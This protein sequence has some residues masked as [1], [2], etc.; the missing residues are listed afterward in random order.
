MVGGEHRVRIDIPGGI[1]FELAEIGKA[2]TS[3]SGGSIDL[4]LDGSYG[5]FNILRH[6]ASGV[7]R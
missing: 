6:S 2:T 7:V 4:D 5:L 3:A 1:E